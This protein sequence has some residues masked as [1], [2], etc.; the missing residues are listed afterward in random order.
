LFQRIGKLIKIIIIKIYVFFRNMYFYDSYQLYKK[1]DE[2]DKFSHILES[3]NYIK[4]AGG[5]GAILPPV[6]FEFGCYSGRTFSTAINSANYLQ[7]KNFKFYAFD[8]FLG[9]PETDEQNIF[10]KGQYKFSKKDFKKII[11]KKTGV[12]LEDIYIIEGFYENSLSDE[13]A[14][15]LPKPGIIHIDCDLYTSTISVL[16]FLKPLLVSGSILLFDDYYCYPANQN[17][18]Q[19]KAIDEFL[20]NNKDYNFKKWK[21]YST[22]GQSFFLTNN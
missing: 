5:N 14:L 16:Q 11:K 12:W 2:T 19:K 9:L 18:G 22:F 10:K 17:L 20:K 4:V 3:V 21:S 6:Y 7:I 8:S 13:V 15:K 1:C